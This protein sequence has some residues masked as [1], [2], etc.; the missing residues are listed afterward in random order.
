[1]NKSIAFRTAGIITTATFAAI[2]IAG[3][4][5]LN[6]Y[7]VNARY[8]EA[9]LIKAKV[10]IGIG[11]AYALLGLMALIYSFKNEKNK[12]GSSWLGVLV[13]VII[14]VFI[15]I[16]AGLIGSGLVAK[17]ANPLLP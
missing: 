9:E 5:K 10:I 8:P 13:G 15:Y 7:A 3:F 16:S 4:S 2:A 11:I 14:A 1:M 6:N 12:S 17:F